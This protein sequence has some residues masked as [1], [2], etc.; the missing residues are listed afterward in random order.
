M[1]SYHFPLGSPAIPAIGPV[2]LRHQVT[3][4][5]PLQSSNLAETERIGKVFNE[6]RVCC[7]SGSADQR[8][9]FIKINFEPHKF[10]NIQFIW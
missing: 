8:R 1:I 4:I 3:L 9:D 10:I 5:L 7:W 2:V 6:N